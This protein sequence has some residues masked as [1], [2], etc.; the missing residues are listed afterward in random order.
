MADKNLACIE[1]TKIRDSGEDM[2]EAIISPG[3]HRIA[4]GQK[5]AAL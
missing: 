3:N 2:R 1:E 5:E 4:G